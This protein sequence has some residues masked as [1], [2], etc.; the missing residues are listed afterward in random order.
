MT[1]AQTGHPSTD[2]TTLQ[3]L[4][5]AAAAI[6]TEPPRRKAAITYLRQRGIDATALPEQ[7]PLGYA[8]PG[9][10]RLIDRLHGAFDDQAL[11]D[12]GLALRSSRGTLIDTFRDRV[13][14]PIHD[15]D[16][17]VA[18]FI[19]RDLSGARERTEVPQHPPVRPVRQGRPAVRA[20]RR[21][22]H[23]P[24]RT[25][26]GH[27]RRTP[28]RP[29]HHRPA[30][31]GGDTDLLPVAASGTAFTITHA[32]RVADIAFRRESPVVVT[33]DAAGRTAAL[34]AGEHLR[35]TGLDVRVAAL[36]N[37]TDPA[38]YLTHN[39]STLDVF[40]PSDAPT[41]RSS[42]TS[43]RRPRRPHAMDRRPPRRRPHHRRHLATYP[44]SHSRPKSAG[45]ATPST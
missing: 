13:I 25:P 3:Q 19:G 43:H 14:F 31:A 9:W 1:H 29:R 30:R 33:A 34:T 15:T 5:A 23:Q 7:W 6:L 8:P 37:G 16:G 20:A 35:Y 44:A 28:R 2:I 40:R 4:T 38:D 27:R 21:P 17:R 42:P 39:D 24:G 12:A 11:L 22:R 32:R 26:T 36:P 10:T 45:S 41:H 18:G